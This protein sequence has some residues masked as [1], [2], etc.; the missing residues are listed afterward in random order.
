[1]QNSEL[2]KA[3]AEAILVWRT[4][5]KPPIDANGK[6]QIDNDISMAQSWTAL[7]GSIAPDKFR[8]AAQKACQEFTKWPTPAEVLKIVRD[9]TEIDPRHRLWQEPKR[10]PEP[11]ITPEQRKE[12][13]ASMK[14]NLAGDLLQKLTE[15]QR[16]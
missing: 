5:W 8:E 4:Y 2:A 12:V 9:R 15:D 13:L 3:V 1:M 10:L 16:N 7:M 11:P 6:K 14:S